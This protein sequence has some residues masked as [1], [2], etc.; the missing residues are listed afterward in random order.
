MLLDKR[1]E[2]N[3]LRDDDSSFQLV[4]YQDVSVPIDL[5]DKV[6]D[7]ISYLYRGGISLLRSIVA[8]SHRECELRP[9]D[10]C[11]QL[12]FRLRS[13]AKLAR[14]FTDLLVNVKSWEVCSHLPAGIDECLLGVFVFG[15]LILL[16][17]AE[18]QGGAD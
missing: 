4:G 8:V 1:K 6:V 13:E 7:I 10:S 17:G 16:A 11:C 14:Y 9:F 15:V 18:H 3:R 5:Q 12:A 2:H